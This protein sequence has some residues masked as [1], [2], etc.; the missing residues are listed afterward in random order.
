LRLPWRSNSIAVEPVGL[1]A[2]APVDPQVVTQVLQAYYPSMLASAD[3]ARERAKDAY[4]VASGVSAAIVAAGVFGN[5][6]SQTDTT[7]TLAVI[8]L[9]LWL[10]A[11]GLF[12]WVVGGSK[13]PKQGGDQKDGSDF[14]RAVVANV[15]AERRT[16]RTRFSIAESV[17]VL[18]I[19]ATAVA[20]VWAVTQPAPSSDKTG[21]VVLTSQGLKALSAVCAERTG[22]IQGRLDPSK[23]GS[24]Y[25]TISAATGQCGNQP[26]ELRLRK[27]DIAD[28][29]IP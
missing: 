8:A 10:A 16:V 23:L 9:I 11:A 29:A 28:V 15:S 26:I 1:D 13:K 24:D 17:S 4:T 22:V 6:G 25:L 21:R 5:F 20:I 18:A 3:A 2:Q 14:V 19:V 7:K 27:T 12:I